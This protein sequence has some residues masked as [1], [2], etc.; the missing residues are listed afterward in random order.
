[1]VNLPCNRSDLRG[2]IQMQSAKGEGSGQGLQR[3]T[4]PMH[5][6]LPLRLGKADLLGA[7]CC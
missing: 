7:L 1:M 2:C 3:P 6:P 4:P 5:F